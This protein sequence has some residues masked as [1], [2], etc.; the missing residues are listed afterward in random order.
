MTDLCQVFVKI[1]TIFEQQ[2]Q[3]ANKFSRKPA[4]LSAGANMGAMFLGMSSFPPS[5][6]LQY[7]WTWLY[8]MFAI[9]LHFN[10]KVWRCNG[11]WAMLMSWIQSSNRQS[12]H[13]YAG[14]QFAP[15]QLCR[16]QDEEIEGQCCSQQLLFCLHLRQFVYDLIQSWPG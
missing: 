8:E 10:W 7:F 2:I 15:T 11:I 9:F 4:R 16:R 12:I 13:V 3:T 1:V 6:N 5:A 14:W